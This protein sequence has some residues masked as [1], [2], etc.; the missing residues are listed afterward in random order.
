MT[1]VVVY[2]GVMAVDSRR[3]WEGSGATQD[4]VLKI[5]IPKNLVDRGIKVAAMA[6]A[7]ATSESSTIW[8]RIQDMGKG[9]EPTDLRKILGEFTGQLVRPNLEIIT[10]DVNGRASAYTYTFKKGVYVINCEDVEKDDDTV[11]FGGS[12]GRYIPS[13]L[14]MMPEEVPLTAGDI[15]AICMALDQHSGGEINIYSVDN[16]KLQR[17]HRLTPEMLDTILL[18]F[19]AKLTEGYEDDKN[20]ETTTTTKPT[21]VKRGSRTTTSPSVVAGS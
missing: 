11:T 13:I 17:N 2:K 14:R 5:K 12:G 6:F 1:T 19:R 16:S 7:G 9:S 21:C 18:C 3:S 10:L 4:D 15:V 8:K 20:E